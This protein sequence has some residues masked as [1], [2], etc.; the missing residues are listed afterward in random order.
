MSQGNY[1]LKFQQLNT[2]NLPKAYGRVC[3]PGEGFRHNGRYI[4]AGHALYIQ[5]RCPFCGKQ[6]LHG[7]PADGSLEEGGE[8][9]NRVSHCGGRRL[10]PRYPERWSGGGEYVLVLEAGR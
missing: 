9:S 3:P 6:H 2:K 10:L 5:I 1:T 7:W 8:G 4:P